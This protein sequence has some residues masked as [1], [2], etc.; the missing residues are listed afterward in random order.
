MQPA[1]RGIIGGGDAGKAAAVRE[2]CPHLGRVAGSDHLT[3]GALPQELGLNAR[4]SGPQHHIAALLN[5][6]DREFRQRPGALSGRRCR[7]HRCGG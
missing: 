7:E 1:R 3:L 4:M 6:T 5:V 2:L